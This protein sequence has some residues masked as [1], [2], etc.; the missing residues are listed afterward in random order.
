MQVI[1]S[2]V[3]PTPGW[4]E[5]AERKPGRSRPGPEW[6]G[7]RSWTAVPE[8]VEVVVDHDIT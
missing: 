4:E 2:R 8:K 5:T 3:L 6:D 1:K 7:L